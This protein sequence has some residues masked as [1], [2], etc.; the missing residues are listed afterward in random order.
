MDP[1]KVSGNILRER[2]MYWSILCSNQ[3]DCMNC[4]AIWD[5][6]QLDNSLHTTIEISW[7]LQQKIG[8]ICRGISAYKI[9]RLM[10]KIKNFL[11][12][13][14]DRFIILLGYLYCRLNM[15]ID[16][17]ARIPGNYLRGFKVRQLC[18]LKRL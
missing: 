18:L 17:R 12:Y 4:I 9:S 15:S 7:C 14:I 8:K 3:R 2:Y 13:Q 16:R 6:D 1:K 5:L 11:L 10:L